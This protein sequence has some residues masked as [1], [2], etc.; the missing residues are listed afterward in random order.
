MAFQSQTFEDIV[1]IQGSVTSKTCNSPWFEW[2]ICIWQILKAATSCHVFFFHT[3]LHLSVRPSD[4]IS[5][6]S[7]V[8]TLSLCKYLPTYHINH[9]IMAQT[10]LFLRFTSHIDRIFQHASPCFLIMVPLFKILPLYFWVL[11]PFSLICPCYSSLYCFNHFNCPSSSSITL[12]WLLS[13][14]ISIWIVNQQNPLAHYR[15][16]N[17]EYKCWC[18]DALMP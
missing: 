11:I 5:H 12:I 14:L 9:H 17:L 15:I 4:F 6:I 2:I 13:D 16:Y 7:H 8:C 3:L 1:P 18:M 10:S